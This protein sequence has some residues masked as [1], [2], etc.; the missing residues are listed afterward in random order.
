MKAT[1]LARP[2]LGLID[3]VR[4]SLSSLATRP[5]N[6]NGYI[7]HSFRDEDELRTLSPQTRRD[8]GID[9]NP[10][11]LAP[12]VVDTRE[13]AKSPAPIVTIKPRVNGAG[14]SP[15]STPPKRPSGETEGNAPRAQSSDRLSKG[16]WIPGFFGD[17]F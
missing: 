10:P 7:R 3:T 5:R 6:G 17:P 14:S 11:Q 8:I 13:E 2:V 4:A 9:L 1:S 16:A 12:L 15:V